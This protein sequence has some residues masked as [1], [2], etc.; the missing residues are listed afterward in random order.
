MVS[1]D[2]VLK[3]GPRCPTCDQVFGCVELASAMEVNVWTC[4]TATDRDLESGLSKST[5][6]WTRKM[7]NYA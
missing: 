7:V 1:F 3:H 6:V 2:P 4:A 5:S